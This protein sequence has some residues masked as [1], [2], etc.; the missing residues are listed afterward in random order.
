MDNLIYFVEEFE[1]KH[2]LFKV[3]YTNKYYLGLNSNGFGLFA[4]TLNSLFL[5]FHFSI[6]LIVVLNILSRLLRRLGLGSF[7]KNFRIFAVIIFM[8]LEGNME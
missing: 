8:L 5:Q 4:N 7:F 2:F 1:E 3:N 6:L